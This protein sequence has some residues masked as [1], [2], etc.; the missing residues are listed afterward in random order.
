MTN[1]CENCGLCCRLFLI[2]LSE[3]EY[4]S[5][6]YK[7]I[8]QKFEIIKDFS[9]TKKNGANLLA[10]KND[11]SCFYLKG[12]DCEIHSFRPQACRDFFCTSKKDR[13]KKMIKII[14]V[15][16]AV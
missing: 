12:N 2:N 1:K 15:H 8:L 6:K 11:G 10:Q 4:R 16:R 7:T 5:G 14:S 9:E 13:F 3:K